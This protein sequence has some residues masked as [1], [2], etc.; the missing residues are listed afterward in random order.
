MAERRQHIGNKPEVR[1]TNEGGE[2]VFHAETSVI[3]C[4]GLRL[5]QVMP[6]V[7]VLEPS[8]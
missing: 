6:G 2:L 3:E 5:A 8:S 7:R 1:T 4:D